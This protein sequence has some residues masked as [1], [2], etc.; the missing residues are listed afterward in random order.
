MVRAADSLTILFESRIVLGVPVLPDVCTSMNGEED[1]HSA[2][3]S[4]IV[5][6]EI[7]SLQESEL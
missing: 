6:P 4:S 3:N 1:S 7:Y 2:I 5:I